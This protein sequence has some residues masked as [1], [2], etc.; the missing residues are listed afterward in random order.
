MWEENEE[1]RERKRREGRVN[2][3][4]QITLRKHREIQFFPTHI[5]ESLEKRRFSKMS[6]R[7]V[8]ESKGVGLSWYARSPRLQRND[9]IE[10]LQKNLCI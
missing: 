6:E 9:S 1:G 4:A 5:C 2:I 3:K 10:N 8:P 7:R